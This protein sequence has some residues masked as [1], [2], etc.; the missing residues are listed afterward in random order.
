MPVSKKLEV[1][2]DFGQFFVNHQGT[3]ARWMLE[4]DSLV[5]IGFQ[6]SVDPNGCVTENVVYIPLNLMVLL[7]MIPM[8]N[9]YFIG[10][11]NPTFS[12]QIQL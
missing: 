5:L 4:M 9:G 12:D 1:V 10:N 7:I 2:A 8:K 6:V 3:S 11:I